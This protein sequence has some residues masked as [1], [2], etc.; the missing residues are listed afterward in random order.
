MLLFPLRSNVKLCTLMT[1]K[2]LFKL[3]RRKLTP[4]V[5]AYMCVYVCMY[6]HAFR[7]VCR[8]LTGSWKFLCSGKPHLSSGSQR[9]R[10]CRRGRREEDDPSLEKWTMG[11]PQSWQVQAKVN[12]FGIATGSYTSSIPQNHSWEITW[13]YILHYTAVATRQSLK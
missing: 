6:A 11:I 1:R 5:L 9:C 8:N 7:C 13:A 4:H 2:P 12:T 10:H 3:R